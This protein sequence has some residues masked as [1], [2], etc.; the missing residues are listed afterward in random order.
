MERFSSINTKLKKLSS[1]YV[2][3]GK[4]QEAKEPMTLTLNSEVAPIQR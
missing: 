4:Y 2:S 3:I 1:S